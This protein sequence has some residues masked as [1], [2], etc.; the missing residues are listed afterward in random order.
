MY[1]NAC[2]LSVRVR[3]RNRV[4]VQSELRAWEGLGL[5]CAP[6]KASKGWDYS[7]MVETDNSKLDW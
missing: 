3:F 5:D 4:A 1:L 6:T 2:L 7:G